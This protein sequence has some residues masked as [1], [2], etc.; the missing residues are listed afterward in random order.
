MGSFRRYRDTA[1]VVLLLAVPFFFL[2]ASIRSPE[3]MNSIDRAIS[4]VSAPVEYAAAALARGVSTLFGDYVYLVDVKADNNKL[5]HENAGLRQ[6]VSELLATEVENDRLRGLLA[7]REEVRSESASAMVVAKDTTSYFRVT[8]VILDST[9]AGVKE[10]MPVIA[11][12]GVVGIVE[13]VAGE[14]IDV[15]LAVDSGFGV[16]VYVERTRARGFVRGVGDEG[17]YLV[18]VEYVQREDELD[19]GDVLLT[20]GLGCRFPEGIPV[21]RVTEVIK[22]EFG[23][24]QRVEARPTVDFSRLSEVLIL[25][26]QRENCTP[27][28]PGR[29]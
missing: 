4:R 1:L 16:D 24:Y 13:R 2:R 15:Q 18:H 25:L 22:K 21:A 26:D 23:V 10:H 29:P 20:S 6:R 9:A 5:A 8:R 19:V 28:A 3:E 27:E 12:G 11:Q 14:K 7:L 17:Q